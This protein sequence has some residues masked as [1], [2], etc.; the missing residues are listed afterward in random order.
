MF[1]NFPTPETR[2]ASVWCLDR[3]FGGIAGPL[4]D[5]EIS[6][7]DLRDAVYPTEFDCLISAEPQHR[8]G[9]LSA[10]FLSLRGG[11]YGG[12]GGPGAPGA[13]AAGRRDCPASGWTA[14]N[15]I[16]RRR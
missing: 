16:P 8:V 7:I 1:F 13:P 10:A 6:I 9:D 5:V 14:R 12:P 11:G 15:S 4:V 2:L 3:L